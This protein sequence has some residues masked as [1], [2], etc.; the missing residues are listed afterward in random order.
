MDGHGK[1][2]VIVMVTAAANIHW[3]KHCSQLH[4][5]TWTHSLVRASPQ[6]SEA[7][8]VITPIAQMG[9]QRH[10]EVNN[11]F[12]TRWSQE[13]PKALPWSTPPVT[14]PRQQEGKGS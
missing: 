11:S 3:A 12:R 10:R 2:V 7:G 5:L 13:S 8:T 6:S 9:T 4:R 14:P 1:T